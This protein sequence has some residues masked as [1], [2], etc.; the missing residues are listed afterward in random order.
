[1]YAV[2]IAALLFL[3]T[4]ARAFDVGARMPITFGETFVVRN[5]LGIR[6]FHHYFPYG[7]TCELKWRLPMWL[8]VK[9]VI[10]DRVLLTI[11]VQYAMQMIDHNCPHGTETSMPLAQARQRYEDYARALDD[12][13]FSG[14]NNAPK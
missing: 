12:Q 5:D 1:M 11:E 14:L 8:V 10:A 13:T 4:A 3:P 9:R 2:F 6:N 7:S